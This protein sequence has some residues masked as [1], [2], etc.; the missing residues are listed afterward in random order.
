M[1]KPNKTGRDTRGEHFTQVFR[2][3]MDTPAWRA[4][5][6]T[7]QSLY[8]WIK[9]EWRGA[10]T[11]NNGKIRLSV[12]QAAEA[13]GVTANTAANGFR[14]LQAKGF[15]VLTEQATLGIEGHARTAS[16]EITELAMPG[17][18][19]GRKLFMGWSRDHE[20]QVQRSPANNPTGRRRKTEPCLKNRD[21]AVI[22]FE[23]KKRSPSQ[24]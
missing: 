9:L 14:E 13:M 2:S 18:T 19:V 20:F 5:S 22:N 23:T 17:A 24:K 10:R 6:T 15:L 4:L 12:R 1:K 7:A 16:Y 21:D 3:V 11:N 8:P